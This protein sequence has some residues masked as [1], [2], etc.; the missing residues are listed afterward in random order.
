MNPTVTFSDFQNNSIT[1]HTCG[2]EVYSPLIGAERNA[3]SGDGK[4]RQIHCPNGHPNTVAPSWIP[5]VTHEALLESEQRDTREWRDR[6]TEAD[7]K[8]KKIVA[9]VN[10][11]E[12]E[13]QD[14]PKHELRST[15][16]ELRMVKAALADAEKKLALRKGRVTHLAPIEAA[17]PRLLVGTTKGKRR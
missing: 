7:A 13:Q 15:G 10:A 4:P 8:L 6:F 1:C 16:I 11:F 9:R 12:L 2:T 5:V 3:A 17:S 14:K